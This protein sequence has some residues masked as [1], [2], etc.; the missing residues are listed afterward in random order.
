MAVSLDLNGLL[1]ATTKPSVERNIYM[2]A[3]ELR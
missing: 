1:K 2:V 3:D